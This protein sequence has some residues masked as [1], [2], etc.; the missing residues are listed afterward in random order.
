VFCCPA[1]KPTKPPCGTRAK[2]GAV[3]EAN[4]QKPQFGLAVAGFSYLTIQ[5]KTKWSRERQPPVLYFFLICNLKDNQRP[6]NK[7]WKTKKR[8]NSKTS[9]I[10]KI[11][12]IGRKK[13]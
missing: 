4:L 5:K 9:R 13:A 6:K 11:G 3:C 12:V 7:A 1:A 10:T 8:G 2:A